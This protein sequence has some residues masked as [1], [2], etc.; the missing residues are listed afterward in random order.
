MIPIWP[1]RK[2][3]HRS[4]L[5]PS[6]LPGPGRTR[7]KPGSAGDRPGLC[8]MSQ[9]LLIHERQVGD[10]GSSTQ[11]LLLGRKPALSTLRY[12]VASR[13]L[14]QEEEN[15]NATSPH[16]FSECQGV[17]ACKMTSPNSP[18]SEVPAVKS[19]AA[20]LCLKWLTASPR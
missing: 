3:R 15:R 8:T 6:H 1:R 11:P 12:S 7:M 20:S 16:P 2:V 5:A 10:T 13:K 14:R 4:D 17:C 19:G 9:P 18:L